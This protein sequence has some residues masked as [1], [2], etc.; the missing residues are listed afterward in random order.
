MDCGNTSINVYIYIYTW[1]YLLLCIYHS[2]NCLSI[3][4]LLISCNN[5]C[6][7]SWLMRCMFIGMHMQGCICRNECMW[8]WYWWWRCWRS[9]RGTKCWCSIP[10]AVSLYRLIYCT[11]HGVGDIAGKD[12]ITISINIPYTSCI[13]IRI[14]RRIKDIYICVYYMIWDNIITLSDNLSLIYR[15]EHY[16]SI[17]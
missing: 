11:G 4:L 10:V 6:L 9:W 3:E 17:I 14:R 8:W 7:C 12:S 1:L 2:L 16:W 13:C 5:G 15:V